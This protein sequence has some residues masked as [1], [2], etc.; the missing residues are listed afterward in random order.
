MTVGVD[1]VYD[2]N[3]GVGGWEMYSGF[4]VGVKLIGRVSFGLTWG[5]PI[6]DDCK[7]AH[8]DDDCWESAEKFVNL[9]PGGA[10]FLTDATSI[11]V[12]ATIGMAAPTGVGFEWSSGFEYT[13]GL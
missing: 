2:G 1:Y 13:W 9:L 12:T 7:E 6:A 10:F 4:D 3:Y 11:G 8:T 5:F